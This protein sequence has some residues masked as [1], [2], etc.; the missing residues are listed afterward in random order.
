M[1]TAPDDTAVDSTPRSDR[2]CATGRQRLVATPVP[3]PAAYEVADGLL[4][5]VLADAAEDA[6]P[7]ELRSK[8][9]KYLMAAQEADEPR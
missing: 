8:L 2:G 6:L 7:P 1:S 9:T 3:S 4:M 5:R